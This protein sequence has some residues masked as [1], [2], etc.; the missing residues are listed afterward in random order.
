MIYSVA[1]L[2]GVVAG[3][4]AVMAPAAVSWA[5]FLGVF[6]L[7][8][9]WLAFLGYRWTPWVFSIAAIGELVTDQLASTPSRKVFVQ[10]ATRIVLGGLS[11][12]VVGIPSGSWAG[13]AIV[14]IVGAIVGTL[15]GASV[16]SRMARYFR[17][18]RPAALIEDAVALLFAVVAVALLA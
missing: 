17:R 5:A 1:L 14:G 15:G 8:G 4:R 6:N 10:F 3:L 12:A 9:N 7:S 11:G 18:D 13:T 2:L 16:R